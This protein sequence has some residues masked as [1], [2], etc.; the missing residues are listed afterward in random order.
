MYGRWG[1]LTDARCVFNG[2]MSKNV[3][4]W[5]IMISSYVDNR[6]GRQALKVFQKM[7]CCDII[8]HESTFVCVLSACVCEA[9][10]AEGKWVHEYA[11]SC[12]VELNSIVGTALI[13]MYGRCGSPEGAVE[14]FDRLPEKDLI[15]WSAMIEI[16]A[17]H[18]EIHGALHIFQQMLLVGMLPSKVTYLGVIGACTVSSDLPSSLRVHVSLITSDHKED[19][20]VSNAIINMYGK[21]GSLENARI[22]FETMKERDVVTWSSMIGAYAQQEHGRKAL[23]VFQKMH[24]KNIEPDRISFVSILDACASCA[25]LAKGRIIH[26]FVIEKGFESDIVVKTSMINLYAKCGKL[27]DANCL[28]QKMETRNSISWNA[29]ISAY[30]QHGYSKSALKLFNYMVR[31]AVIPTKVTFYS[32]LSAC[33]FA[34]MIN[35]AQGYFDSMKRD[36]GLTPEDV[37]YNCLIDLYGRAGRL[38]EGENLIRNM[39]CSPTCASWMSLL[40]ACR[41]KLDVPRAKYAA[42]RAAEL[43]PNSAAPFVMLSNIYAACGMW[44]EV[45]EVRKYI[46]D[47]GLKKQ[48]GRSSIE[49]DGETHDF[50][51]ADEAHPKCR[52]IYAELERLNQDMKE[53]GYSPDTKVVLHDVNEET[54]EQVLCYHSERIALAFGLISTPPHTSLRIIKNLRA[55][56]DCHSAFKFISKLLCREIVVR[57]ATRFHIIKDGVCSCADYW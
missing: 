56:P 26:M 4:S 24:L 33:S 49:I 17:Q 32:V 27:A 19:T 45:N 54:K 12:A 43:D 22:M 25:T 55:C 38:E 28:F 9:S 57:D 6:Q 2:L 40:G 36:Y 1:H 52:E 46:K 23:D 20:M 37:H 21:C 34:G 48:P 30:A 7:L 15:T 14:I 51:V 8:P 47:K 3:F 11:C 50:S 29:M 41:V 13:N 16:Y 39:Q 31:E 42:E 44:K 53:V 18:G 35:E 5:N 10:L